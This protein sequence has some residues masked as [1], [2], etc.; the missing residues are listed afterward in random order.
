MVICISSRPNICSFCFPIAGWQK[1]YMYI[2]E[3]QQN[4]YK[5]QISLS[6]NLNIYKVIC[7][8]GGSWVITCNDL[9]VQRLVTKCVKEWMIWMKYK[10]PNHWFIWG[11]LKDKDRYKIRRRIFQI[12]IG[13]DVFLNNAICG[14]DMDFRKMY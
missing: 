1:A 3:F 10:C 4:K 5:M 6:N 14:I 12:S 8:N 7:S 13:L 2:C 11:F 9:L